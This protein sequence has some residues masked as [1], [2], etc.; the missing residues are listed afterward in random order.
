MTLEEKIKAFLDGRPHAVVGASTDRSKYGNKV[1]RAYLQNNRAVYPV[2]R[3]ANVVEGLK[4]YPTLADLP[5]AV[6]GISII[7]PPRVTETVVERAGELGI[8]KIW[9]QPG[10]GSDSAM[11]SAKRLGL[12]IIGGGPCL[13]VVLGYRE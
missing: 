7:T 2:N 5:E 4:A 1:V 3:A 8:K 9:M 13:L 6:H 12:N 10:A 11:E